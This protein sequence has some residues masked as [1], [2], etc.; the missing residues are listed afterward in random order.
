MTGDV[1]V[2][3]VQQEKHNKHVAMGRDG[4]SARRS[5][6]EQCGVRTKELHGSDF[7]LVARVEPGVHWGGMNHQHVDSLGYKTSQLSVSAPFSLATEM[8]PYV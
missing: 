6:V 4:G 3:S 2:R 1:A 8:Q 5:T 7:V